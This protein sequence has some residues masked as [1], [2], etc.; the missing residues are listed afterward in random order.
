MIDISICPNLI[1][2]QVSEIFKRIEHSDDRSYKAYEANYAWFQ[3]FGMR[4]VIALGG[5]L[6]FNLQTHSG[7]EQQK[8]YQQIMDSLDAALK[9]AESIYE[10]VHK[11]LSI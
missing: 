1:D 5:A 6:H 3:L 11:D 7:S 8:E 2:M 4:K 9:K 10:E